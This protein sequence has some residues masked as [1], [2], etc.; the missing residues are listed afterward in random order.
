MASIECV[1]SS[2]SGRPP[3]P[4]TSSRSGA[5]RSSRRTGGSRST[6]TR[7]YCGYFARSAATAAAAVGVR[8]RRRGLDHAGRR[9]DAQPPQP[10]PVL[11]VVVEQ[12]A[13]RGIRAQVAH[14]RELA[15]RLGLRVDRRPEQPLHAREHDRHLM[16]A[17]LGRERR[18]PRHRPG[19]EEPFDG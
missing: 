14:A 19:V 8:V 4:R 9:V 17:P 13:R 16:R 6:A 7:A 18:E 12:Q 1:H 11:G 15:G 10:R 5:A 3:D 2:R